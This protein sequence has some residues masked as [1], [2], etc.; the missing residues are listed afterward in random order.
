MNDLPVIGYSS[1]RKELWDRQMQGGNIA[2]R[3]KKMYSEKSFRR[4]K[5]TILEKI[6]CFLDSV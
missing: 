4:P 3:W 6:Q 5:K 2:S 1:L